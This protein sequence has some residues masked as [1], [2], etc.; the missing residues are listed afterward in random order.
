MPAPRALGSFFSFFFFYVEVICVA[1]NP[2]GVVMCLNNKVKL[3]AL[4][5]VAMNPDSIA[6]GKG[7]DCAVKFLNVKAVFNRGL[8]ALRTYG[9]RKEAKK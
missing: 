1:T 9:Q 3:V 8:Q 7:M 6:N 5:L 2:I 4:F